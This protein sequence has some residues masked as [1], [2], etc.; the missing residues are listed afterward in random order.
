MSPVNTTRSI[1]T[2]FPQFPRLPQEIQDMVWAFAN[3]S[4]IQNLY[5]HPKHQPFWSKSRIVRLIKNTFSC[6]RSP[7]EEMIHHVSHA[8]SASHAQAARH[9]LFS[10]TDPRVDPQLLQSPHFRQFCGE[11]REVIM[12][13]REIMAYEDAYQG[14]IDTMRD[15]SLFPQLR[16]VH[17]GE[18]VRYWDS[19][20]MFQSRLDECGGEEDYGPYLIGWKDFTRLINSKANDSRYFKLKL[21]EMRDGIAGDLGWLQYKWLEGS[22]QGAVLQ[23]E[24]DEDDSQRRR[25]E[26][27][28]ILETMPK[29]VEDIFYLPT[30]PTQPVNTSCFGKIA[31]VGK[32][33]WDKTLAMYTNYLE[34]G[35]FY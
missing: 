34:Y 31:Q 28:H 8:C 19:G 10:V 24:E 13:A 26:Q 22:Y 33:V 2:G 16:R 35:S 14:V 30:P 21:R 6:N 27:Q 32:Q 5:F 15:R 12:N 17:L 9:C 23:D 4:Y 20:D 25:E 18:T 29:F 3:E 11:I 7:Q 1:E